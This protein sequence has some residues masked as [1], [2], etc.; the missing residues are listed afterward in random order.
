MICICI[1]SLFLGLIGKTD[2]E[3]ALNDLVVTNVQEIM[4]AVAAPNIYSYILFG[5][6]LPSTDYSNYPEQW[7]VYTRLFVE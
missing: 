1:I 4:D 6:S 2:W 3:A 7:S 5:V